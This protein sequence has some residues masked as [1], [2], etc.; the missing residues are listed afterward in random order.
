MYEVIKQKGNH[1]VFDEPWDDNAEQRNREGSSLQRYKVA[2]GQ[3]PPEI[4]ALK[5]ADGIYQVNQITPDLAV[6]LA[7][8]YQVPGSPFYMPRDVLANPRANLKDYYKY[9]DEITA[10]L[11]AALK[12]ANEFA[13]PKSR[14]YFPNRPLPAD[15]AGGH[16]GDG[17]TGSVENVAK[18]F[19]PSD[20]RFYMGA[21]KWAVSRRF[22]EPM[23]AEQ[24]LMILL[25]EGRDDFGFNIGQWNSQKS[26][27]DAQFQ[28]K[29]KSAGLSNDFQAGFVA[30]TKSK[31]DVVKRTGI[32]FYQAWNGG[33]TNMANYNAQ[34]KA[35]KD[36]RNK[37]LLDI[38]A[39]ALA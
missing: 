1:V 17:R 7:K 23:T 12:T 13:A 8:K 22:L 19:D 39:Q 6:N 11:T 15:A 32:N 34:A 5:G 18:K 31:M 14:F 38:I 33:S 10:G 20:L 24:W 3:L 36:P 30:L 28:E 35:V 9:Q 16:R 26:K 25:T 2:N 37:P 21:V 4:L 27:A 29:L